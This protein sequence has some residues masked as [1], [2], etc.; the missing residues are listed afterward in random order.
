[1]GFGTSSNTP[2]FGLTGDMVG[3]FIVSSLTSE[4]TLGGGEMVAFGRDNEGKDNGGGGGGGGN[5]G[6]NFPWRKSLAAELPKSSCSLLVSIGS[7]ELDLTSE[8]YSR[9]SPDRVSELREGEPD[10]RDRENLLRNRETADGA[11][12]GDKS[13]S[14]VTASVNGG[15]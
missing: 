3:P 15:T 7:V 11:D 14:C 10:G 9:S 1:M 5:G 12:D 8:R 6:G 4:P 2:G 13:S